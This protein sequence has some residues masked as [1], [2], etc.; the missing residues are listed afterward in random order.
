MLGI[1]LGSGSIGSVVGAGLAGLTARRLGLGR[2]IVLTYA[3]A[4]GLLFLTPL[5][6]GPTWL[7]LMM[8][9]TEECV[10]DVFWTIH[11]IHSLSMRQAITPNERLGRVNAVFLFGSQ[12]L[13]PVGAVAAGLTAGVIGVQGGLLLS[14]SGISVAVL[15]LVLSPLLRDVS[16]R[17]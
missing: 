5:A 8:L 9:L 15:W 14:A 4:A 16:R 1:L 10:G 13:R 11:G 12:G 6:G 7:A 2:S 17:G 3:I